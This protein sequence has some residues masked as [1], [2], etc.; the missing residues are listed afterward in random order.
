MILRFERKK[1]SGFT[2]VEVVAGIVVLSIITSTLVVALNRYIQTAT[3]HDL[4]MQ[5]FGMARER[6]EQLLASESVSDFTIMEYSE[7]NRDIELS[8]TVE[9]FYEPLTSRM[10]V[11]AVCTASYYDNEDEL[12]EVTLTHW[13]TD[14]S[15]KQVAQVLEQKRQE[16]AYYAAL[17]GID[18]AVDPGPTGPTDPGPE[19]PE[20]EVNPG[21]EVPEIVLPPLDKLLSMPF[22][23]LLKLL[24]EYNKQQNRNRN[25]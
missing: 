5:A 2:L 10:W 15:K 20:P 11:R 3:Q 18:P 1:M 17:A 16:Q 14:L 7:K 6:M 13:L 8:T 12:Q 25:R 9:S 4:R 19:G 21:P 22:D 23:E 24:D